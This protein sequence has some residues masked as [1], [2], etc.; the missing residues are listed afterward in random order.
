MNETDSPHGSVALDLR[1]PCD[2]LPTTSCYSNGSREDLKAIG[3][4]SGNLPVFGELLDAEMEVNPMK[5]REASRAGIPPL[6]RGTVYRY[7]L[8]VSFVDKSC[9]MTMER[10]Q[11][12]DFEQLEATFA[13]I[14]SSDEQGAIKRCA[15]SQI[16]CATNSEQLLTRKESKFA[17]GSR[18]SDRSSSF[19]YTTWLA[20]LSQIRYMPQFVTNHDR[21]QRMESAWRALQVSHADASSDEVNCI[22]EL[23]LAFDAVYT[24]ARD[25]YF[26]VE[27]LHHLLSHNN[28]VLQSKQCLQQQ[29]GMFLMLFR[30]TNFELYR[31][32]VTE[33]VSVL[34]WVPGMLTTLLAGRLHVDDLLCL[35]DVYFADAL[36]YLGFPLHPYVCLAILVQM[37]EVL[38]EC[39]KSGIIELLHHLP[40]IR[41]PSIVQRAIALR[42]SV[43]SQGLV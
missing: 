17:N 27:S 23:A 28:N 41:T 2:K 25:I 20:I 1:T 11:E 38:I 10:M 12:K 6:Y 37:T 14:V 4:S 26:S 22:F 18:C 19:G 36:E 34:E 35:W 21:R 16:L 5:L 31:H 15:A 7:L 30:A 29:C 43:L 39:E 32:F 8:G 9:E 42:E 40:R 33:G 13:Q 3:N 24:N